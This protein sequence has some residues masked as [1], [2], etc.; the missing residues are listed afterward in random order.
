MRSLVSQKSID[1][2]A[3]K[4][5]ASTSIRQ[6]LLDASTEKDTPITAHAQR[7]LTSTME[8][9]IVPDSI[10]AS[11]SVISTAISS[12]Q[13]QQS[14]PEEDTKSEKIVYVN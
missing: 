2:C 4:N 5:L 1:I 12:E 6:T 13:Q 8:T 3:E 7:M 10:L 11:T 14:T 9:S